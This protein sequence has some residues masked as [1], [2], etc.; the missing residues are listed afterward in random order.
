MLVSVTKP[1]AGIPTVSLEDSPAGRDNFR[2]PINAVD[3]FGVAGHA[4]IVLGV[5]FINIPQHGSTWGASPAKFTLKLD[6]ADVA[7]HR[8]F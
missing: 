2:I 7:L 4:V 8:V 5:C 6:P 1:W 3:M